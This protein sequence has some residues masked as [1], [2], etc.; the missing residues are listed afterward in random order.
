MSELA[1]EVSVVSLGRQS[2]GLGRQA[3]S[4]SF[5]PGRSI[6]SLST[7]QAAGGQSRGH[8]QWVSEAPLPMPAG[9]PHAGKREEL[10]RE[11][12]RLFTQLQ[13][14]TAELAA[15]RQQAADLEAER[16][17]ERIASAEVRDGLEGHIEELSEVLM[18]YGAMSV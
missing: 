13:G 16:D 17:E 9:P 6:N 15:A 12:K 10:V 7:R 5:S 1:R 14:R 3:S 8:A 18:E 11:N 2:S 4:A